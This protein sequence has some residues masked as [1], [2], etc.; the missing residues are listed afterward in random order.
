MIPSGKPV[1]MRLKRINTVCLILAPGRISPPPPA[2]ISA[3]FITEIQ[4]C[5][6]VAHALETNPEIFIYSDLY[7]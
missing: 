6:A 5:R 4:G 7:P 1:C 2:Q 3:N